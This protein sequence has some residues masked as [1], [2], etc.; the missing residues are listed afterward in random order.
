VKMD[1]KE[2]LLVVRRTLKARRPTFL[3][4]EAH[5]R[6]RLR[7]GW[8]RPRGVHSKMRQRQRG[9]PARVAIGY[10]AP[11]AVRGLTRTGLRPM[12]IARAEQLGAVD[13]KTQIAIIQRTVGQRS[14]LA[15]FKRARELSLP[16]FNIRNI[17]AKIEQIEA[18]YKKKK[19]EEKKEVKAKLIKGEPKLP[20]LKVGGK[21]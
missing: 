16:I 7:P 15:I 5:K 11:R 17:G 1:E 8:R 2:Q 6:K 13:K 14:R 21:K 10:G 3:R 18:K 12:L 19:A 4:S 9:K 20:K